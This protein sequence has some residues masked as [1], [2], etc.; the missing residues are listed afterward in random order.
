[1]RII[2]GKFKSRN[3]IAPE[4]ETTRPSSDRTREGIFN[5]I[6]PYVYSA[7]VLDIF[8]GSGALAI[9]AI[10]RGAKKATLI[11]NND[12]ALKAINENINSLKIKD[13]CI[14]L[15]N[16]YH[17]IETINDKFDIILLDPP[18]KM[19]VMDEILKIIEDKNLLNEYGVI[20]YESSANNCLKDAYKNY[21]LK[22]KKYGIAY[23]SF[24]FK[25]KDN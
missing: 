14:I 3:I 21:K 12:I 25:Q 22:V 13:E 15:N 9:E 17:I 23:V 2:A 10:S 11:E 1:M 8:S 18:Y 5:V 7:N 4:N 19:D 20:V 16:D 24:L 6:A